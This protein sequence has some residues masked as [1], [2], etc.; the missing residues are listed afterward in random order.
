MRRARTERSDFE[1]EEGRGGS[2][3]RTHHISSLLVSVVVVVVVV[4]ASARSVLCKAGIIKHQGR[5]HFGLFSLI[6][7]P[8]RGRTDGRTDRPRTDQ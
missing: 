2:V 7:G 3:G 5:L 4:C 6:R 8:D 1:K